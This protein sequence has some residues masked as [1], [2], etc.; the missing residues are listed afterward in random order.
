MIVEEEDTEIFVVGAWSAAATEGAIA[1]GSG[2]SVDLDADV[3]SVSH[4]VELRFVVF[5]G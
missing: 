1:G 4:G 2:F 5:E 3:G